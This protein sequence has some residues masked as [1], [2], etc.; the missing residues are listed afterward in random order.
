MNLWHFFWR[1]SSAVNNDITV[2]SQVDQHKEVWMAEAGA[3]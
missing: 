2:V 1:H 3:S